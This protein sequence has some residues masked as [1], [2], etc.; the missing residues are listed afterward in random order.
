[1]VQVSEKTPVSLSF[2]P[3]FGVYVVIVRVLH[4][5]LMIF[6]LFPCSSTSVSFALFPY[7]FQAPLEGAAC[8]T[9]F[10]SLYLCHSGI[11]GC[12]QVSQC[13]E[14]PQHVFSTQLAWALCCAT[15]FMPGR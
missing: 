12:L 13:A 6:P 3:P 9:C 14:D 4:L 15:F 7:G 5:A 2:P 1:M 11:G 10:D 8:N